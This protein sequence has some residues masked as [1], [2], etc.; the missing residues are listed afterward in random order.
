MNRSNRLLILTILYSI[1]YVWYIFG[2]KASKNYGNLRKPARARLAEAIFSIDFRWSRREIAGERPQFCSAQLYSRPSAT[3]GVRDDWIVCVWYHQ[4]CST[5]TRLR[6]N[7]KLPPIR[8]L[9]SLSF[10][11]RHIFLCGTLFAGIRLK[12]GLFSQT[13]FHI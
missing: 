6:L 12:F 4:Q 7:P 5:G 3:C 9:G 11:I 13:K 1:I 8:D 10:R 2:Y